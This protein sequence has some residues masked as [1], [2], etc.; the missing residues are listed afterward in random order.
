LA[1]DNQPLRAEARGAKRGVVKFA[2]KT[3]ERIRNER[4]INTKYVEKGKVWKI[5][6]KYILRIKIHNTEST[7]LVVVAGIQLLSCS[8]T[9]R[10]AGAGGRGQVYTCRVSGER[11]GG[12]GGGEMGDARLEH[13]LA[14]ASEWRQPTDFLYCEL[15]KDT[16]NRCL[17]TE[18]NQ[19][20]MIR[21]LFNL[22]CYCRI[23]SAFCNWCLSLP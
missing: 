19:N 4:E 9:C 17:F 15:N 23:V 18:P 8:S 11:R 16:D 5:W 10:A 13:S 22:S 1:D 7:K 6:N 21:F 3:T 12:G 20:R 14:A 2:V